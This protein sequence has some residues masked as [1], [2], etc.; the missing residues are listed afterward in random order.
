MD[1]Y[2][3]NYSD[4][5][6]EK[7]PMKFFPKIFNKISKKDK[8]WK[9]IITKTGT[10]KLTKESLSK[11]RTFIDGDYI[12]KEDNILINR[13][14]GSMIAYYEQNPEPLNFKWKDAKIGKGDIIVTSESLKKYMLQKIWGD[15]VGNPFGLSMKM[16]III[17]AICVGV[18]IFLM[19]R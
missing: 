1:D 18:F 17:G 19:F 16:I 7:P 8:I 10:W 13:K 5:H 6:G 9:L 4:T 11:D 3:V 14:F 12:V 2:T 15:F